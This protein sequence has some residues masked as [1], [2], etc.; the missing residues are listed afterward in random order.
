MMVVSCKGVHYPK[1]VML[2]GSPKQSRLTAVMP[3]KPRG[4]EASPCPLR[5]AGER[6]IVLVFE[7]RGM[8]SSVEVRDP[9]GCTSRFKGENSESFPLPRLKQAKGHNKICRPRYRRVI[10]GPHAKSRLHRWL[11]IN[12]RRA[13]AQEI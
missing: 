3:M 2:T 1:E 6:G 4:A 13:L 12:N 9:S 8:T 5:V 11:C 7:A 10:E